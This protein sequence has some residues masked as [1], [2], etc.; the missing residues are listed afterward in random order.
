M[1]RRLLVEAAAA[2]LDADH[3]AS[4]DH[5]VGEQLIEDRVLRV[6][7]AGAHRAGGRVADLKSDEELLGVVGHLRGDLVQFP[8]SERVDGSRHET[9][10]L[11][12]SADEV[13]DPL[14]L[15]SEAVVL[16]RLH[17]DDVEALACEV[18]LPEDEGLLVHPIAIEDDGLTG[19]APYRNAVR[20]EHRMAEHRLIR[21]GKVVIEHLAGVYLNRAG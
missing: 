8:G 2:A 20:S 1:T 9:E 6:R 11:Q 10:A 18:L 16:V 13:R 5:A 15:G 17:D 4:G 12:R 7:E 3:D 21:R 19:E 14:A